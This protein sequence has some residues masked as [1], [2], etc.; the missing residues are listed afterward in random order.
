M[1]ISNTYSHDSGCIECDGSLCYD[2]KHYE[3]YCSECGLVESDTPLWRNGDGGHGGTKDNS[4]GAGNGA[5]ARKKDES[6]PVNRR[7]ENTESRTTF[8]SYDSD[9]HAKFRR[10][11]QHQH[12][13]R[14]D[15][16]EQRKHHDFRVK[17]V[18][19]LCDSFQLHENIAT[20]AKQLAQRCDPRSFNPVGGP[21]AIALGAVAVAQNETIVNPD[22]YDNRV[23]VREYDHHDGDMSLFKHLAEKHS[24]NW[25][26]AMR[27]VKEQQQ[28]AGG[29]ER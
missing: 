9:N 17:T 1:S 23:Q 4:S 12:G 6:K 26:T 18:E 25:Q 21:Y 20:K 28:S 8:H 24:V 27:K 11:W 10:M 16:A 19:A 13:W 7:I 22:E 3:Y 15:N 2:N 14:D 29:E 5:L